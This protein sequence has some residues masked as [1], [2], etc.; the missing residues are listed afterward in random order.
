MGAEN[1]SILS[2]VEGHQFK[3]WTQRLLRFTESGWTPESSEEILSPLGWV[4]FVRQPSVSLL[5]LT[6]LC[7]LACA[8]FILDASTCPD[9]CLASLQLEASLQVISGSETGCGISQELTWLCLVWAWSLP[10]TSW[11]TALGVW[12]EPG[13]IRM[14]GMIANSSKNPP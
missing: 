8:G 2:Q 10:F 14:T 7:L 9:T 6:P 11:E 3:H 5:S 4:A 1:E 12:F 13:G